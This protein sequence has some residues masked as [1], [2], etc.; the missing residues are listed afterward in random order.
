M[1]T[2]LDY[3]ASI[4]DELTRAGYKLDKAVPL[5]VIST[6]APLFGLA[7]LGALAATGIAVG[8]VSGALA[9]PLPVARLHL[10][11]GLGVLATLLVLAVHHV[12]LWREVLAFLAAV[13]FPTVAMMW[14]VPGARR[15]DGPA[16][17]A[18][19]PRPSGLVALARGIAGLWTVS[20]AT[21]LGACVMA[22]LLSEWEFMME[23]REFLGVKLAHVLPVV[24]LGLLITAADAP[25]GELWR[26]LRA[27]LRQP[28]LLGYGIVII[29][30]ATAVVFALGRTGNSGLPLL[31]GLELKSRVVLERVLIARP[32]TKE[33]LV[34]D[35]FMVLAFAL[36]AVGLRRW[37]LP[38][39]M[40]GAIGQ[41][42]LVNSFSH[43]HTPLVYALMR[44]VYALAI[45]SL[46][47]AVL[48]AVL[49]WARRWW[50]PAGLGP[51]T[52]RG[53]PEASRMA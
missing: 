27:W 13:A 43:I 7:A 45:G 52:S 6:P 22:A 37:V 15:E 19:P 30:I 24:T 42:G 44:T 47:G 23:I 41:V 40:V 51:G 17:R 20:A 26:R 53:S 16:R 50:S 36:A 11:V 14:L 48:V 1:Q 12:T 35:P 4:A 9:R 5:P 29:L 46:L 32:R 49:W 2:N 38:A 18:A 10:G 3:V 34:G 33:W 8:E 28:L 25:A 21:V 31:G 39:A